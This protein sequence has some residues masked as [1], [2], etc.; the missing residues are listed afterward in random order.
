MDEAV[1]AFPEASLIYERSV[2]VLEALG[3]E[4]WEALGVGGKTKL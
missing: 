3:K 1:G 2:E 4:G